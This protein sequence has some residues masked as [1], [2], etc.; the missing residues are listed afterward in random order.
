MGYIVINM[1]GL[2][3]NVNGLYNNKREWVI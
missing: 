1:N 2:V 3:I